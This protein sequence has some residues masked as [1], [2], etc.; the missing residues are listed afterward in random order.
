MELEDKLEAEVKEMELAMTLMDEL[1]GDTTPTLNKT[2][3]PLQHCV[4]LGVSVK[5]SDIMGVQQHGGP[6]NNQAMGASLAILQ[7]LLLPKL[8]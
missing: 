8:I 7:N 2:T 1:V 4:L 3:P 6:I 5:N